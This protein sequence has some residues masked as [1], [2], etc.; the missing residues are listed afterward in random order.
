[1]N[2]FKASDVI[3]FAVAIETNGERFYRAFAQRVP[4]P[5]ARQF[6]ELL[7]GE[8]AKH[9]QLFTRMLATLDDYALPE[10]Y[11]GE[12]FDYLQAY[13]QHKVFNREKLDRE[14]AGIA[15]AVEAIDFG[16]RREEESILFY[17]EMKNLVPAAGKAAVEQVI[18]EE[19][20]HFVRLMQLRKLV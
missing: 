7:A 17:I 6:F 13:T 10:S 14:A 11:P 20:A 4:Q 19:R 15:T 2:L 1:M 12:Y 5:E 16:V 8:E 9:R 18:G 3:E